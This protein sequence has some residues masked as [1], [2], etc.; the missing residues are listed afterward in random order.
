MSRHIANAIEHPLIADPLILEPLY[1][2]LAGA[3][4]GHTN[5]A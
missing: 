2:T 3:R 5:A 4:G 1:Q